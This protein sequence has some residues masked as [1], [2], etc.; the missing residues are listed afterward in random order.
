[1]AAT[2]VTNR[3][4]GSTAIRFAALGAI[5]IVALLVAL[6][7]ATAGV[8]YFLVSA[9]GPEVWWAGPDGGGVFIALP[10]ELRLVNAGTFLLWNL[11]AAGLALIVSDLAWRIRRGVE[12][13]P[14]VSRAAWGLAITLGAGSWLA[15]IV[16]NIAGHAGRVF[17]DDWDPSTM[18]VSRLPIDWSIGVHTFVPN[19][20]FLGLALVLGVLAYIVHA[21]ERIQRDLEG[22]I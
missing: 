13:V 11:T 16:G 15:Q 17:P 7:T 21:C 4:A 10:F 12:F 6:V 2:A 5:R 22:L 1:M 8:V 3:L 14:S 18:D 19:G 9:A 20:P